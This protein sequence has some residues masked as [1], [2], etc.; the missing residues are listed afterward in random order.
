MGGRRTRVLVV[1]IDGVRHDSLREASTP[2]IDAVAAAGS[3][4]PTMVDPSGP[5]ISGPCW[6]TIATGTL[7]PQHGIWGNDEPPRQPPPPDFLSRAAAAGLQ[8]AAVVSWPPL[9]R[10]VGCGP[11]FSLDGYIPFDGRE[12]ADPAAWDAADEQVGRFAA[13]LLAGDGIDVAFVYL[14][15]ADEVAHAVGCGAEY[16]AA[17]NTCDRRLGGLLTATGALG[18]DSAWNVLVVT[19]HGHVDTGGHGG[20]TPAE[21]TAWI[22]GC[23]PRYGAAAPT[24]QADIHRSV[25]TMAGLPA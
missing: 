15:L 25:L 20:D 1:G 21:R 18:A 12:P 10:A 14:G 24:S 3:L 11:I 4:R 2:W 17:I 5:T 7:P 8:T 23:G 6:A 13:D 16:R 19:D 9:L 22:A